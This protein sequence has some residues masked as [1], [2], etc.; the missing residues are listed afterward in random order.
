MISRVSL[1]RHTYRRASNN[2]QQRPNMYKNLAD[3]STNIEDVQNVCQQRP[4]YKQQWAPLSSVYLFQS[5]RMDYRIEQSF[6]RSKYDAE[7]PEGKH[8]DH[9][10][11]RI[12]RSLLPLHRTW[13]HALLKYIKIPPLRSSLLSK[14]FPDFEEKT[15][16]KT[17]FCIHFSVHHVPSPI[18]AYMIRVEYENSGTNQGHNPSHNPHPHHRPA[19]SGG[20]KNFSCILSLYPRYFSSPY[21][22][23][24]TR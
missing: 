3:K 13:R 4:L 1:S 17:I 11:T 20:T 9:V 6:F 12:Y 22:R 18:S 14:T 15:Q 8:P 7:S 24:M 21:S 19:S 10:F 2:I 23:K 5:A 16:G